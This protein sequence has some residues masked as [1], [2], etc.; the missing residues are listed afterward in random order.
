MVSNI[1]GSTARQL[2]GL[3]TEECFP[4]WHHYQ[5]DT[6]LWV[7]LL[8]DTFLWDTLLWGII[9]WNNLLSSLR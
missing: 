3:M 4:S 7:T 2:L 6:L 8:W 9:Q 1:V 5:C